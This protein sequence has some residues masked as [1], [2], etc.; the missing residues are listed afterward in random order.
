ME[1]YD[2]LPISK[3][4]MQKRGWEEC[5]FVF[6]TGDAYIDHPSFGT[7]IISRVL[8]RHGY[9]V[10]IIAQPD[11]NNIDEFRKLGKPRL[12][13]IINSGNIDSMVNHY[14][15]A[16]K[17][18]SKDVYS[19]GDK[20]DCRPDRAVIV[21]SNK[22]RAAYSDVPIIIGGIESSLR[23]LGHYDYW[24]D[25]VRKSILIDS[26]ADLLGYGMGEHQIVEI[27]DN[28]DAGIDIKYINYL[29]GIAFK[30]KTL[31]GLDDYL[32]LPSFKEIST[33][34]IKYIESFNIQHKN[35]DH[36]SAKIL[37]EPYDNAYVVQ[38]PPSEPLAT[39][40]LDDVYALPYMRTY[41][42]IYEKTGGISAIK[43]VKFSLI[44][45]RGCYGGC[46]FCALNFH[47]GRTVTERSRQAIVNEAKE[48]VSNPD[49][50]GYIHDVGGPTAN[51]RHLACDKQKKH[52]ACINKQCLVPE[53]CKNLKIDHDDYIKLLRELREIKGVKKVFV[54]SGIRFDYLIYDKDET[55]FNELCEHHI[56]GQLKVA[57][58]HV[59][60]NVLEKMGK[61][62][63]A[64][65]ERF[66]DK[67]KAINKKLDKNQYLVPYFISSHPGS[68]LKDAINLAE[69]IRD[70]GYMPEQVQDF[71]PT[72][73]T[74]STCMYYTEIDPRTMKKIYVPKTMHDK[75]MQR[76]LIQYKKPINYKLVYEALTEAGRTDLIGNGERCLIKEK[77][78]DKWDAKGGKRSF[79]LRKKI[80]RRK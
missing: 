16:K 2:F 77:G 43:E 9:R 10:G 31:E 37:V 73:G 19:P 41:H 44:S 28:L 5:D 11:W 8:E 49:F 29:K 72:P 75:A 62:K 45:S 67:Y 65:Y 14:T 80:M 63:H 26:G 57:P 47:Q 33:D 23:R 34:K 30:T 42:P 13:F 50:K 12:A 27:A 54:R 22:A 71:Y 59:S 15:T 24:D 68:T 40:E 69:Y 61:P 21:Y 38:N 58:E 20:A 25:K 46:N 4:D 32:V 7:A 18:R 39:I 78:H 17:K 52:G 60:D 64:V 36:I 70:L 76:A 35:T 6:I 53:P 48:I 1:N 56:S 51:F 3:E 66:V 74:L 79:N 55:F